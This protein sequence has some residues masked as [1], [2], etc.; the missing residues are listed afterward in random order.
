MINTSKKIVFLTQG[1]ELKDAINEAIRITRQRLFDLYSEGK[2]VSA[3][4]ISSTSKRV[5]ITYTLGFCKFFNGMDI[6]AQDPTLDAEEFLNCSNELI[7]AS[8]D[9]RKILKNDFEKI[10]PN[11]DIA[12]NNLSGVFINELK[13]GMLIV[14]FVLWK[15]R[16]IL[17]TT[18]YQMATAKTS[19]N[20]SPIMMCEPLYTE[21]IAFFQ[22]FRETV[23]PGTSK[24][25]PS[26][27]FSYS[28]QMTIQSY[29]WRVI[30][31]T[32]WHSIE[33]VKVEDCIKFLDHL[34][35]E[36]RETGARIPFPVAQMVM[37]LETRTKRL[38]FTSQTL[39]TSRKHDGSSAI[40]GELRP[41]SIKRDHVRDP[42]TGLG[43]YDN[44]PEWID[45]QLSYI[46]SIGKKIKNVKNIEASL[47]I[48]N[49]YLFVIIPQSK[50][51]NGEVDISTP[52]PSEFDRRY[53]NEN[54]VYPTLR[55]HVE[56]NNR[57]G[58]TVAQKLAHIDQYFTYLA[59]IDA[60]NR[61]E[62]PFVNPIMRQIDFPLVGALKGTNKK[63][64]SQ[65]FTPSL[66][67]YLYAMESLFQYVFDQILDNNK[68]VVSIFRLFSQNLNNTI[69]TEDL[70][71][72]PFIYFRDKCIPITEIKLD[73]F[74]AHEMIFNKTFYARMPAWSHL[75]QMIVAMETG[76]RTLHIEWLDL[77]TYDK[78]IDRS[79][80]LTD[81]VK[82]NV[83]TDK[84]RGEPWDALVS[85]RVIELLDR[86]KAFLEVLDPDWANVPIWYDRHEGS[87]YGEIVP[88][89][90]SPTITSNGLPSRYTYEKL[91]KRMFYSF[92][93][94]ENKNE[95]FSKPI[96]WV[97]FDEMAGGYKSTITPHSCRATI[98][99][100]NVHYLPPEIIGT[101]ITG[102]TSAASVVHYTVLDKHYMNELE[103]FQTKSVM[104]ME[105]RALL[106]N[107]SAA[108]HADN[109]G[110]A[111]HRAIAKDKDGAMSDFSAMSFEAENK[112][113][114]I[115]S[116]I[117]MMKSA[118]VS[119]LAHHSTHICP[120]NN[121]CPPEVVA[122]IGEKNC[123]RCWLGVKTVDHLLAI[124]AHI[125]KLYAELQEDIER[126]KEMIINN[127]SKSV[128]EIQEHKN[129][130]KSAEITA[131][132]VS[133]NILEENRKNLATKDNF[134]IG[135]PEIVEKYIVQMVTENNPM[136]NLLLRVQDAINYPQYLT[137][138]LKASMTKCRNML[139]IKTGQFEQLLNEPKGYD[140]VDE[141][142]GLIRGMLETTNLSFDQLQELMMTEVPAV[143]NRIPL[144]EI[145]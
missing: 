140:Q 59:D 122:E 115:V 13:R 44:H 53:F 31:A 117:S 41:K 101:F 96:D 9:K 108:I 141:F 104:G 23:E 87:V 64:I 93:E 49:E 50:K 40:A 139:L 142:R 107:R 82:L 132:V 14:L 98:V 20:G 35:K 1:E 56:G 81:L 60:I 97:E 34:V 2:I 33:D 36:R 90:P 91:F 76:L 38:G 65:L 75:I 88:A 124:D 21:V 125:R 4:N 42:V 128:I 77:R 133:L 126:T 123:G 61:A 48:L 57:K 37:L 121:V 16:H 145:A 70:G 47:R 136:T 62:K 86:Q 74:V 46:N 10:V 11:F 85:R 25:N 129:L 6:F 18:N 32:D 89:F 66:M 137:P 131:W 3:D 54:S 114:E 29:A 135:K 58:T 8:K 116:G 45:S 55:E 138:Q 106:N 144:L 102:H 109:L 79:A 27:G 103:V 24:I 83:S 80:P 99:S 69:K 26:E 7:E 95:L 100:H 111:L 94:F 118:S 105:S 63:I 67:S 19:S 30:V 15:N 28:M 120:C 84:T 127:A 68:D 143:S 72:C 119:Q 73:I 17:L 134:L 92:Q 130:Q 5:P 112:K 52:K 39:A 43:I 113:G 78:N 110:S 12:R 71:Y 51:N 22:N